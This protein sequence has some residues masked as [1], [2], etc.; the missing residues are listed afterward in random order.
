MAEHNDI[1]EQG[2]QLACDYLSTRGYNILERNWR[3]GHDEL[4]I[5]AE[6]AH[7][8]VIVE[9]KTRTTDRFGGPEEAVTR[10]KQRKLFRATEAYLDA[11]PT[12]RSVRFD[13]VSIVLQRGG[14][15]IV[16]IIDAFHHTPDDPSR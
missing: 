5:V 4:D 1:G 6:D 2:E 10:T 7:D 8:L 15:R 16:H 11:R 13:V 14:P 9:V 3:A 12:E